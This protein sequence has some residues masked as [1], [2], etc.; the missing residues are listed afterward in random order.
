MTTPRPTRR[1]F[2]ALAVA[3]AA[4]ATAAPAAEVPPAPGPGSFP[5]APL[6]PTGL[7]IGNSIPLESTYEQLRTHARLGV[8]YASTGAARLSDATPE[9]LAAARRRF[10]SA[11]IRLY[12]FRVEE[13]HN[14]VPIVLATPERDRHIE[15]FKT[16]LRNCGAAGIHYIT[17]AH[18]ANIT[19]APYYQTGTAYTRGDIPTRE[20]DA[21]AGAKLP[22]THGRIYTADELWDSFAYFVRAVM[23]VAEQAG[24]RIG[25]HP[26][27]PPLPTLGGIARIFNTA[28]GYRRAMKLANNSPN[29][30][31]CLC[32]GTWSEGGARTGATPVE[33]IRE[34]GS[35]GRLFKVHFRNVD[36]PLPRFKETL[37]EDG[38]TDMYAVMKALKDTGFN[39][40]I[41]PDHSPGGLLQYTLGYMKALRDRVNAEAARRSG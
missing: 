30:G 8:E 7:R 11:G 16:H 20:F 18:I 14:C 15:M 1:Q 41:I 35:Q 2:A 17:Y 6:D 3:A 38:Y 9:K 40:S 33:M 24:V 32:V 22:L 36:Q 21:A 29:F 39:G 19:I 5:L 13:L 26:D 34:F 37:I 12:N 25:V 10:E 31:V 4:S 23:P 28:E 27:D